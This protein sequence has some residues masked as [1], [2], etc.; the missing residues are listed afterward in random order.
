ME[1]MKNW[2]D[3]LLQAIE[4]YFLVRIWQDGKVMRDS[5]I[6]YENLFKE[7]LNERRSERVARQAS[8]KKARE[9]KAAKNADCLVPLPESEAGESAPV[10]GAEGERRQNAVPPAGID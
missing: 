9:A 5:A 3:W 10:D 7:W 4:L 2:I 8:A 1:S 6:R